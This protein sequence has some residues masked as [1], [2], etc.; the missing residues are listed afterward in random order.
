MTI[1]KSELEGLARELLVA[2]RSAVPIEAL[3]D[4][5]PELGLSD[6][7]AIQQIM[8]RTW[9]ESGHTV[10][11][12]RIGLTS[13]AM[14]EM[15]G[16][17]EPDYGHILDR[18]VV[19]EGE[20]ISMSRLIA[21]RVESEICFLLKDDL[22]GPGVN[23][24]SV[25]AATLGVMPA[26]EIIDS[27]IKDWKIKVADSIADNASNALV[28]LGG[29]LTP[30]ADLDLRTIG[31]VL[32][33]N[34]EIVATGAGA[35]VMGNPAQS[36]AWLANALGDYGSGLHAGEFIMSGSLTAAV[37]AGAGLAFSATFDHLG[38]VR[39]RFID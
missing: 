34:G 10:V 35:A 15:F 23:A 1:E 18:V 2:E 24:A 38:T 28:V 29:K 7:Y 19:P 26:L 33:R 3:T 21:P 6:A 12:K 5:F 13:R 32:E 4:R 14:Q 20:P 25:L 36:V 39:A 22:E 8:V 31:M 17:K 27:R 37:P 30:V 11:G 16:L 9:T